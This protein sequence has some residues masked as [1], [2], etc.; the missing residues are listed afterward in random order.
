MLRA[1]VRSGAGAVWT[2]KRARQRF[3]VVRAR[4]EDSSCQRPEPWRRAEGPGPSCDARSRWT[5]RPRLGHRQHVEGLVELI[6]GQRP[7]SDVARF[8]HHVPDG[9]A[10]LQRLLGHRG[11][12][13]VADVAVQRG[14]DR[15]GRLGQRAAVLDIGHDPVDAAIGQQSADSSQQPDRLQH[16]AGH[17]RQHHVQLEVAGGSGE[18]HGRVVAD[19]LGADHGGGFAED[20]V[21]LARHDRRARLQVGQRDLA[22]AGPRSRTHPAQ[23]VGDLVQAHRDGPQ[24][25]RRLDQPVP[26]ALGLEMVTRLGQRQPGLPDDVRDHGGGEA[27]RGIDPGADRGPAQR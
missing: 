27:G 15:G 1:S 24:R 13:L 21:H 11:G 16:V 10:L 2:T 17:H 26:G 25:S 5:S 18:G 12:V 4:E 20:R 8:Q 6:L 23:V 14:D 22:E 19:H 7:V 9:L 3:S